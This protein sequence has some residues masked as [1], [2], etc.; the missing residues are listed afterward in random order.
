[1]LAGFVTLLLTAQS[2]T[3]VSA[4]GRWATF[5][6]GS[7]CEARGRSW[8]HGSDASAQPRITLRFDKGGRLLVHAYLRRQARQG[9]TVMLAID[10]QDYLLDATGQDAWSRGEG[11]E[12][13]IVAALRNAT[14]MRVTATDRAGVRFTD[15]Y[16]LAG[17]NTAIDAAAACAAKKAGKAGA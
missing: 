6:L 2:P 1:M 15:Y 8:S 7:H 10:E 4:D 3:L 13:A 16:P 14:R 17:I 5:D 12:V 9:A 11:Q